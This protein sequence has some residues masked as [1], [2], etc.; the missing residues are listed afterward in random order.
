MCFWS[1]MTLVLKEFSATNKDEKTSAINVIILCSSNLSNV[2][3]KQKYWNLKNWINV[4]FAQDYLR[5]IAFPGKNDKVL[6][7][8][9]KGIRRTVIIVLLYFQKF[10]NWIFVVSNGKLKC[11][12][13]FSNTSS[14]LVIRIPLVES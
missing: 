10:F 9:F 5:V 3:E 8:Y 11:Y 13:F 1:E 6:W 7:Y 12:L 2:N 14:T 4:S